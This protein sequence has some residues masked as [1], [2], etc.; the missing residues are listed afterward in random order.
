VHAISASYFV[1]WHGWV[2]DFG[3]I[4]SSI[5]EP[6][7]DCRS[8]PKVLMRGGIVSRPCASRHVPESRVCTHKYVDH[9]ICSE[10]DPATSWKRIILQDMVG[11]L[12]HN[13]LLASTTFP[14]V[15]TKPASVAVYISRVDM[16]G[17]TSSCLYKSRIALAI[18]FNLSLTT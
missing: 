10:L 13:F 3:D 9:V 17:C 4:F 12:Y 15:V 14:S 2:D 11:L 7:L 1:N 6:V 8:Q 18:L 5:Y 16:L